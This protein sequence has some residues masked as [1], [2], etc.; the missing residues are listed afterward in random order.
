MHRGPE[1]VAL[2]AVAHPVEQLLRALER[3]GRDDDIAAG[4][5]RLR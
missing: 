3:E 4:A 2:D 1:L 5:E